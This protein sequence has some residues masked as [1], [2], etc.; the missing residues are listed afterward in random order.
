MLTAHDAALAT[1]PGEIRGR[2]EG[3]E[4]R[5]GG[6]IDRNNTSV[7]SNGRLSDNGDVGIHHRAV[8]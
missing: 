3:D 5:L 7:F 4:E 6:R 1:N 2:S 8:L